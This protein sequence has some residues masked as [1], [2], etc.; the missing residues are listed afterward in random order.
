MKKEHGAFVKKQALVEATKD[1]LIR[2]K[3]EKISQ[4]PCKMVFTKKPVNGTQQ[5]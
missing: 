1:D 2:A 4:I 3:N 5:K